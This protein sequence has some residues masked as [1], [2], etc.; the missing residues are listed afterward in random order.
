[1]GHF[2]PQKQLV[3][4]EL[5]DAPLVCGDHRGAISIDDPVEKLLDFPVNFT[6]LLF[7]HLARL[8]GVQSLAVPRIAER[9]RRQLDEL[10]G[11]RDRL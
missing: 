11:W 2:L 10:F 9:S 5:G 6:Q 1:M 8:F 4:L 7:D 3:G